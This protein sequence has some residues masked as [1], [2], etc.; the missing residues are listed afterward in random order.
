MKL[1]SLKLSKKEAKK[2]YGLVGPSSSDDDL[3]KYPYGTRIDFDTDMVERLNLE[4]YAADEEVTIEAAGYIC[5]V[6]SNE[7]TGGKKRRNLKIQIT[8]IAIGAP[9]A[10]RSG[11]SKQLDSLLDSK[12]GETT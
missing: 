4:G 7:R 2:D 12:G 5:E 6:E 8:D 3:P 9:K 1:I 10:K 11:D